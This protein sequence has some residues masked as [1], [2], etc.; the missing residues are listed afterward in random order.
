MVPGYTLIWQVAF[1]YVKVWLGML[2]TTKNKT[3][4]LILIL[5]LACLLA[6]CGRFKLN[7]Y[8]LDTKVLPLHFNIPIS[9]DDFI[10]DSHLRRVI[11]PA[12][13]TGDVVLIDPKNMHDQ[14]ISGFSQ[15]VDPANPIVGATAVAV[16]GGYLFGLDQNT[17][18]IK[19]ID[20]STNNVVGS[21]PLKTAGDYIRYISATDELWVTEKNL[22]QIEIF[23]VSK[24]SP[25]TL[26]STGNILVPNGPE[27]LVIDDGRGLAY[28][29]RPNQSLT[30]VI[31]VMT[32]TVISQ[33]GNGCSSA[34]GMAV[35]ENDGYLFVACNEGKLVVMDINN[36][37]FQITSQNY[38]GELDFVAYNPKLHHVYLPSSASG[39]L[40]IFQFNKISLR[41]LGT[42]DTAIQSKCVTTDDF[43]NIW[44]CDPNNGQVFFIHDTFPDKNPIP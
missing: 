3:R 1:C 22:N 35:D 37:G 43:N 33:W 31:Q 39:I 28:T 11:I 12:G 5:V 17:H 20:L 6:G 40:A 32:H 9:F 29:N 7:P 30:D 18:T 2:L 4:S 41:L 27:G 42:A 21:I 10:Y 26:Q 34:K 14:V 19:T 38:G 25:P 8:S 13:E 15:Q 16:A 44:V 36:N 24:D 23:S